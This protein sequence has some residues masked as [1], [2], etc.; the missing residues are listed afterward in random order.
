MNKQTPLFE[1]HKKLGA[2]M[3]PFAGFEMPISYSSIRDEHQ[4][5]REAV[6]IFDVSHMGS[7][8]IR[9]KQAEEWM[10]HVTSNAVKN[11]KVG[12]AQ[13]SC[14][15]NTS[16]GIVDDLILYRLTEDQCA[17]GEKAYMM[18]VNASNISK[19]WNWIHEHKGNFEAKSIN[20][21]DN[22]ALIA[23]QGP[24]AEMLL[25]QLT[26]VKLDEI[27]YY[28]FKKGNVSGIENVLISA[29]GYTGSGGFELYFDAKD[30][31]VIWNSLLNTGAQFDIKP[32]GL[33]ARDTLRLEMGY[34]LY[35]ND[36]DDSTNPI[37]AGLGWITKLKAKGEFVGRDQIENVKREGPGR[38]L[39]GFTSE[40]RRVPRKDYPIL[41][42]QEKVIGTVTSGT[43][44][45]TL[46]YPV[47]MGYVDIHYKEEGNTILIDTGRKK[48]KANV[49]KPPFVDIK[50]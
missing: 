18:V 28:H 9:G 10:D 44:S 40:E 25:Q 43:L 7:F 20:I 39:V 33:G 41:D 3:A 48:L 31:P 21:S 35:G 11:L 2:K 30:A 13:Y 26:A 42:E 12:Q 36:I 50:K 6:G 38:R 27:P 37:E 8:I 17:E 29:T 4:A 19:D 34:C 47:G 23:V 16:G 46:G 14:L 45:P 1:E 5:V 24:K 49:Q 32:C 22:T 15:P